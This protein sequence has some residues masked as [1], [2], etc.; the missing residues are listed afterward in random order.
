MGRV[1]FVR[2]LLAHVTGPDLRRIPDPD[3]VPQILD[4]FDKP[5]TVARGFHADQRRRRQ[6]L[7][8]RFGVPRGMHQLLLAG[9]PGLRVQPRTLVASWDGNHTL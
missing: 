9:F 4:Q 8:K 2:L 7:I 5:L 3:L 6:L 1:P